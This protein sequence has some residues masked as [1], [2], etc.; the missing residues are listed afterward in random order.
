MFTIYT[1]CGAFVNQGI[2]LYV[3]L[4]KEVKNILYEGNEDIRYSKYT[5]YKVFVIQGLGVGSQMK[6]L[7][8][9][10]ILVPSFWKSDKN[11]PRDG[12]P[13]I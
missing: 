10:I 11:W 1:L 2:V 7:T 3:R 13:N 6:D 8:F 4:K 9:S 5:L 12:L